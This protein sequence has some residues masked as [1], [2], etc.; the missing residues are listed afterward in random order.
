M[1]HRIETIIIMGTRKN[2]TMCGVQQQAVLLMAV[3]F[4]IL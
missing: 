3:N 4:G 1:Q 2:W